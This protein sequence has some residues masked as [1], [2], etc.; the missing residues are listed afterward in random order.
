MKLLSSYLWTQYSQRVTRY[1]SL[2][3]DAI[4]PKT[5]KAKYRQKCSLS[6][7]KL[8]NNPLIFNSFDN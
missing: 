6:G 4:L 2:E 8:N 1:W 5:T 3:I 7:Y